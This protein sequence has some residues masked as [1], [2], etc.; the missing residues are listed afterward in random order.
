MY[1]SR[2]VQ[3]KILYFHALKPLDKVWELHEN[4]ELQPLD[5]AILNG[6]WKYEIR[7]HETLEKPPSTYIAE[8]QLVNWLWITIYT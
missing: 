3:N 1:T 7:D 8:P 2:K 6:L 4:H 5:V